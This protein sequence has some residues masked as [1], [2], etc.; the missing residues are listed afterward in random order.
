MFC[1]ERHRATFGRRWFKYVL[2]MF[3]L[4]MATAVNATAP[5]FTS[6]AILTPLTGGLVNLRSQGAI[7]G[8]APMTITS[9]S[10][11]P[12][13][14]GVNVSIVNGVCVQITNTTGLDL[15]ALGVL[16]DVVV[17]NPDAP[18]GV[19]G[20]VAVRS[21]SSSNNN[22]TTCADPSTAPV[23][24][25]GSNRTIADTDGV[26]G[27]V[28][29][30]NASAAN[31][32]A[33]LTYAWTD[34]S[35]NQSLGAGISIAP[36]LADG[37]HQVQLTVTDNSSGV[38]LSSSATVFIVVRA[39][40]TQGPTANAGSNRNLIDT[41]NLAGEVVT[42][43]ASAS[44]D[45]NGSIVAYQWLDAQQNL[46][47][48]GVRLTLR[49]PDGVNNLI[50]K[51]IDSAQLSSSIGLT[52]AVATP[53]VDNLLASI[54]NLTP[55]QK[56]VATALDGVC[57]RL[58]QLA[59]TQVLPTEQV[60]LL[61]RCNSLVAV[62]NT[63]AQVNALDQLSAHD[64]VAI[65]TQALLFANVQNSNIMNR[66][67]DMRRG[68]RG[69]D[70][71]GLSI[72]IGG[73]SVPLTQ[74]K[75]VAKQVGAMLGGGASADDAND[76]LLSDKWGMWLRGNYN[77]ANG[78]ASPASAGF[79]G[80]QWGVT[81]GVDYRVTPQSFV[82]VALGYGKSTL[83]FN[84]IGRGG[85]DTASWMWSA[86]GSTY[87]G[88]NFYLDAIF[89]YGHAGY[90]TTRH[91]VYEE[92]GA[93]LDRTALGDTSGTTLSGGLSL[94]YDLNIGSFTI[95]PALGYFHSHARVDP[96]REN[97]ASGLDLAYDTQSY[98]SSTANMSL[99]INYAWNTRWL[100]LLPHV[101]GEYLHEFNKDVEVFGVR[102]AND[103]FS[104]TSNP[105]PLVVVRSDVPDQWYWRV[106]AGISAQFQFG[107][108]AYAE[109]QR[110]ADFQYVN[111]NDI[112]VGLRVQHG[113]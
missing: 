78:S 33:T 36:R 54:A 32:G 9:V 21:G 24:N 89:N 35:T 23:A 88:K 5:S 28:V 52:I 107:V 63:A 39:P 68:V 96:F 75:E 102:F 51:V 90:D 34:L 74:L 66:F 13:A 43:D 113:F 61:N 110:L 103:P 17:T 60:D 71:D 6:L 73:K 3:A 11:L 55:N 27:E 37:S 7:A 87:V 2:S 76:A 95:S 59:T 69:F 67:T 111:F 106:A 81:G 29:A 72:G 53:L 20:V 109:Y 15:A 1:D 44:I 100:V 80:K 82:G 101:R 40:A 30:L 86:Y 64:L 14:L 41:D 58:A 8:S 26:A 98:S 92:S 97:G 56:S 104:G 19:H 42:L 12:L 84:P 65:R 112:T 22:L 45:I 62:T 48:T 99:A 16:L 49:L 4:L 77:S 83:D 94:G 47:G 25:A 70:V 31:N 50:L 79:D 105:T 85:L 38:A 91:I 108:S 93:T 18:K 10:I 46:L 57:A